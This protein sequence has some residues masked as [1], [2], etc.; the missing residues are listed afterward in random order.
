MIFGSEVRA[1]QK[2]S[3]KKRERSVDLGSKKVVDLAIPSGGESS[4]GIVVVGLA[5]RSH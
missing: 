4:D 1:T 2:I 3:T 5:N